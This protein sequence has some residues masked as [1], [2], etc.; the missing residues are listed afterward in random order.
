[1]LDTLDGVRVS[2]CGYIRLL[3][4]LTSPDVKRVARVRFV[5]AS[6]VLHAKP[7]VVVTQRVAYPTDESADALLAHCAATGAKLIYDLDDDLTALGE[8]HP[9]AEHYAKISKTIFRLIEAAD[10]TWVSTREL[11][12]RMAARAKHVEVLHNTL[13]PR[14]W[15]APALQAARTPVR[16]VYMGTSTHKSDFERIVAP[17]WREVRRAHGSGV[18]LILIGVANSTLDLPGCVV[19]PPPGD[20]AASYPAFC[21]WL[22]RLP[23]FDIGLAPLTATR[24]NAAKSHIKWLEYAGL[25][26]PTLATDVGEYAVSITHGVDGL[27]CAPEPAAFAQA[28]N[29]L[30]SDV[31][32]RR[33]ISA[34]A[35]ARALAPADEPRAARLVAC[36]EAG[37][38]GA[39][40]VGAGLV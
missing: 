11:A 24:F 8:D 13:D 21:N 2:P 10:E 1:V 33:L 15:K 17:A 34:R 32:L 30:V 37:A 35:A 5:S 16:V 19:V 28:L 14:I 7:D 40:R 3:L 4:P 38:G 22:Q 18:E 25:G 26:A 27:L 9:E 39:R 36:A 23:A 29:K 31:S 6:D 20:V 12:D